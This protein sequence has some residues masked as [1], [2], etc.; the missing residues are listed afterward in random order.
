MVSSSDVDPVFDFRTHI[1]TI[2]PDILVVTEDDQNAERKKVF[3]VERG[4]EFVILPKHFSVAP[5]STTSILFS[6]KKQ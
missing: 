5:I 3:C 1:D 6:I 2:Q 4:I